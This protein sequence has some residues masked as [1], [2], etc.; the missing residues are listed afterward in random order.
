MDL[1]TA[2]SLVTEDMMVEEVERCTNAYDAVTLTRAE[3]TEA[4]LDGDGTDG[5]GEAYRAVLNASSDEI[6]RALC[7]TVILAGPG[8]V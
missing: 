3:L 7:A 8:P 1:I 5:L 6:F 2:I 4:D